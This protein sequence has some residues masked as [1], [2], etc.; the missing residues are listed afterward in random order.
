MKTCMYR[1][2]Y[3][4]YS[5]AQMAT[6]S[7]G[8]RDIMLDYRLLLWVDHGSLFMRANEK[9]PQLSSRKMQLAWKFKRR[10]I[11]MNGIE[12]LRAPEIAT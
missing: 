8:F 3:M 7:G 12:T 6:H 9:I 11:C 10:A 4:F 5:K 2:N 1:I